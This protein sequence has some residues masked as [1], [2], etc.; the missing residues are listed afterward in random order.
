MP[1]E[2]DLTVGMIISTQFGNARVVEIDPP[3]VK[4]AL[5]GGLFKRVV[6]ADLNYHEMPGRVDPVAALM[7]RHRQFG[8]LFS[9]P[10]SIEPPL[11]AWLLATCEASRELRES[12]NGI[13]LA[14]IG[15]GPFD[16]KAL[17]FLLLNVLSPGGV[18]NIKMSEEPEIILVGRQ[19]W[20]AIDILLQRRIGKKVRVY[21]Q[22]MFL[23]WVLSG[24]DPF[25]LEPEEIRGLAGN[26]PALDYLEHVAGFDWPTTIVPPRVVGGGASPLTRR[27]QAI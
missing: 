21:S 3:H 15:S 19:E 4:L 13:P 1:D 22:E 27:K 9:E 12:I 7:T 25:D 16:L 18:V 2:P 14:I 23:A 26:H 24:C 8:E 11:L 20:E 10:I 17:L 5:N 6:I